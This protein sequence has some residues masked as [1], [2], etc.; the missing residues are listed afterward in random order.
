VAWRYGRWQAAHALPLGVAAQV[1]AGNVVRAGDVVASGTAIGSAV[2]VHGAS[3]LGVRAADLAGQLRVPLGATVHEGAL[4]AGSGKR[5][6]R[7]ARSPI[8]GRYVHRSIDGDLYIAPLVGTWEVRAT[9]DGEVVRSDE[10]VVVVEGEA[11]A[12]AALAAYG[13]DAVG[14]LALGVD[15]PMDELAPSRIDVRLRGS[16]IVGGA[17]VAAEAITRAHACGV[18]GLI[19]GAAPAG[20]LRVVYGDDVN[21]FGGATRE[22]RPTVLCLVGFGSAA[23][24]VHVFRPLVSLAG[25]RAAIHTASARLFVFAPPGAA[26]GSAHA[27][28]LAIADDYG[29]VRPLE[30]SVSM[31][32]P[33]RF[34]S[35][36][37]AEALLTSDG[38][39]PLANVLPF[40]AVR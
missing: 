25:H 39:I 14:E 7:A 4:L 38:P 27:P 18:A 36:V 23:L 19:A 34:A 21:A 26:D 24:P 31:G 13:P 37:A 3:R 35:E 9:L 29:G 16:L 20:G 40:D 11:W 2:R 12:L 10:A 1:G 8:E 15:A 33:T 6:A 22:D 28:A 5:F 30:A 32:G 17:R